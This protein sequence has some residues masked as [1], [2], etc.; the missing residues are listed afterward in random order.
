MNRET[1][2]P[3]AKNF[4]TDFAPNHAPAAD[5]IHEIL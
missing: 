4:G 5:L 2:K 3:P 1:Q